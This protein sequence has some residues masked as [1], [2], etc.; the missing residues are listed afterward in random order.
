MLTAA[1]CAVAE[2]TTN[3]I[4]VLLNDVGT[5]QIKTKNKNV[6]IQSAVR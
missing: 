3:A 6:I 2:I 1:S 5:S 4:H